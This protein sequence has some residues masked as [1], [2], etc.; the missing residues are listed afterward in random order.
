LTHLFHNLCY[1][2]FVRP[3]KLC[4]LENLGVSGAREARVRNPISEFHLNL[5]IGHF[6][7][8]L[9]DQILYVGNLLLGEVG[10]VKLI[11]G[12]NNDGTNLGMSNST[13][14]LWV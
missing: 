4:Q 1:E 6:P 5:I 2:I 7:L 3:I 10:K 11:I 8:F 9:L 12:C 13:K 14:E